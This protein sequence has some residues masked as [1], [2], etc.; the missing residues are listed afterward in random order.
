[1]GMTFVDLVFPEFLFIVGMSI[2]FA[3][4]ARLDRGEPLW[5]TLF[6]VATRTLSL[7]AIGILMVN[8][9]PD[10]GT[11]GW[12]GAL[13]CT[14]MFFSAIL[15]FASLSGPGGSEAAEQRLNRVLSVSLRCLGIASLVW[16]A[17]SF[18]GEKGERIVTLSPF[19]L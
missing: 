2:P 15:A 1:S 5:K 12:S 10:S 7:L 9:T 18:R 8:E 16:L 11:M 3:L 6:H 13:W 19:V 4:G 14:L 17:F